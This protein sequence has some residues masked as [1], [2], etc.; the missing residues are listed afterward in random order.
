[1]PTVA[2]TSLQQVAADDLEDS[3]SSIA[4]RVVEEK[5]EKEVVKADNVSSKE[6]A[7]ILE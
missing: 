6:N 2:P 1:M 4:Q 3:I 7:N 5:R